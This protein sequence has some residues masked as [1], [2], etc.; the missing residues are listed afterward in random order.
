MKRLVVILVL[1]V[2][3]NGL[4]CNRL[5]LEIKLTELSM[6]ATQAEWAA[7]DAEAALRVAKLDWADKEHKFRVEID[8]LK[9]RKKGARIGRSK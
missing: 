8:S 4:L 2:I 1:V 7:K 3:V 6:K 9:G 5:W